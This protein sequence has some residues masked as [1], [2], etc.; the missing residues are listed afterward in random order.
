MKNQN[1]D[2][3]EITNIQSFLNVFVVNIL[4]EVEKRWIRFDFINLKY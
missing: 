4:H 2:N 1:E 3:V